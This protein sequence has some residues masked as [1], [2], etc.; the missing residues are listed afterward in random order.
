MILAQ[1][2]LE[3]V[4]QSFE[5]PVDDC[6]GGFDICA[7]YLDRFCLSRQSEDPET[8]SLARRTGD[9]DLDDLPET[10]TLSSSQPWPVGYTEKVMHSLHC[11]KLIV[12]IVV[13]SIN[14]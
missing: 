2:E 12:Y 10:V 13:N 3:V 1:F 14:V 6:G 5:D 4:V 7:L 9:L 8:C 11:S